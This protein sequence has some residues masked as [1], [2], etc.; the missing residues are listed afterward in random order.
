M[1][2]YLLVGMT[3]T[4]FAMLSLFSKESTVRAS[5][6]LIVLIV[7]TG[8]RYQIGYDWVAYEKLF[9]AV[10]PSL[11]LQY[12]NNDRTILA[13][14]P[15]YYLL[16]VLVKMVGGTTEFLFFIISLFNILVIDWAAKS[17]HPSSR[18]LVWMVYF[19]IALVAVQFNIIRQALASS[20]VLIA[21]VSAMNGRTVSK[22]VWLAVA[23]GFHASTV[24]FL[25]AIIFARVRISGTVVVGVLIVSLVLFFSGAIIVGGIGS[26]LAAFAPS[27]VGAKASAYANGFESGVG[28]YGVTPA[29]AILII[30]H[31]GLLYVFC[32]EPDRTFVIN[33]AIALTL[34]L[35]FGHLAISQVPSVWNRI[36]AV[37]LIWQVA[38]LSGTAFFRKLGLE[39]QF[40]GIVLTGLGGMG[41]MAYQLARPESLAFVPYHSL[42]Q[43]WAFD[44]YGDGRAR[45][46][47]SIARA[48]AEE[49]W[50]P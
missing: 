28:L 12:Y 29:V 16:N 17:I 7:F 9:Q 46:E 33:V 21:L 26:F 39:R 41:M 38:A 34:L 47:Y 48:E 31:L 23:T 13:V 22:Y 32:F 27:F 49:A 6:L 1:L 3:L 18:P 30:L 36:M 42:I 35:I 19:F 11:S 25:P 8:L 15:L 14:E 50:G 4:V 37:A 24:I 45:S 40:L 5:T 2:P 10:P 44:D 43:V 20:F